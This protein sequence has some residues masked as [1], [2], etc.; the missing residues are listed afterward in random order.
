VE[1]RA[2]DVESKFWEMYKETSNGQD[3]DFVRQAHGDIGNILTFVRSFT[4][5][6]ASLI[7]ELGWFILSRQLYVHNR[8]AT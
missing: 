6:N 4:S 2:K 7:G 8:D 3:D 1:Q 5:V